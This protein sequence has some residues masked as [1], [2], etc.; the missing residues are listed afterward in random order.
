MGF[1]RRP[2]KRVSDQTMKQYQADRE[3]AD[4]YGRLRSE[5][6][7]AEQALRDAQPQGRS[8]VEVRERNEALDRAL[9]AAL[10]A[11]LAG[12][13]VAMGPKACEDRIARRR[14]EVRDDVRRW[15]GEVSKLRT[16]RE[17]YRLA[18]MSRAGTLI[19]DTVRM[20]THAMS[21][22]GVPDAA[23]GLPEEAAAKLD[24]P[25]VGVDLD[26][27][28]GEARLRSPGPG[29]PRQHETPRG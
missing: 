16:A 28:V 14:A 20:R 7:L 23:S 29:G 13:R 11:A 1:L 22:A 2:S 27:T 24:R 18:A 15:A 3:L 19:P 8:M 4:D 10:E 26:Q 21:S 6:Q 9:G 12:E 5:A 25:L 17:R